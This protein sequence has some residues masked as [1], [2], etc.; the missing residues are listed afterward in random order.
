V[1]LDTCPPSPWVAAADGDDAYDL[2]DLMRMVEHVG[3]ASRDA[4]PD[5]LQGERSEIVL[6]DTSLGRQRSLLE[7]LLN[8]LLRLRAREAGVSLAPDVSDLQSGLFLVRRALLEDFFAQPTMDAFWRVRLG[9][10]GA[11]SAPT[12]RASVSEPQPTGA[13]PWGHYGCELHLHAFAAARGARVG[14]HPVRSRVGRV[15]GQT[16]AAIGRQLGGS[17][18]FARVTALEVAEAADL[19]ARRVAW[20]AAERAAALEAAWLTFP[21]AASG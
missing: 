21:E 7:P 17:A 3:R 4:R 15:S 12:T 1:A 11:A 16:P 20:S 14:A 13:L 2:R 8:E 5:L 6:D 18:L 19:A 10:S 9:D